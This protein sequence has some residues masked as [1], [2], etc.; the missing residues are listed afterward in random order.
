MSTFLQIKNKIITKFGAN[1]SEF[2]D[3]LNRALNDTITEIN[4]EN[5]E[6]PHLQTT[7]TFTCTASTSAVTSGIPSDFDHQLNAYITV[8][9]KVQP[10]LIYLSRKEWNIKR[11]YELGDSEPKFYHIW[12][13]TLYLGPKP[14]QGYSGSLDYYSFDDTLVDDTDT[15]KLSDRYPR[16]ELLIFKG[17]VAKMYEF[18]DS[19]DKAIDRSRADYEFTTKR[20]R[21][22]IRKNFDKSPESSRIKCWKER[23][24]T[25]KVPKQFRRY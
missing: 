9:G 18:L 11:P 12:N 10:P 7:S 15:C 23:R 22:W 1:D 5:P 24:Y 17:T 3:E 25:L 13:N 16:W 8:N 2:L 19:D 4:A 20:F 6:S 14:D 21:S